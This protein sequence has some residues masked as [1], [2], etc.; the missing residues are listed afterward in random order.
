MKHLKTYE[1]IEFERVSEYY[2]IKWENS[3]HQYDT[4]EF[5]SFDEAMQSLWENYFSSGD[6]EFDDLK[7]AY[8]Q[9]YTIVKLKEHTFNKKDV[10]SWIEVQ[11]YNL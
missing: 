8:Y 9:A 2:K 7:N 5:D 10:E 6:G 3:I 11:K 1:N 4:D